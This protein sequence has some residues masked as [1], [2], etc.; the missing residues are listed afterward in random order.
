LARD[1]IPD[2]LDTINY[3]V[4][5]AANEYLG[6][7][8]PEFF[9]KV[10]EYHLEEALRR[11]FIKLDSGDKPL[12]NLIRIAKYLEST[13]YMEKIRIDTISESEAIVDM[14]GV[15]V[16]KSS[17]DLLKA[18]KHPSHYMTNIMIAALRKLGIVAELRDVE[19]DE[20]ERRFK[21]HW[22]IL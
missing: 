21:E 5:Q 1:I 6:G 3:A 2:F 10:G 18:G 12:N 22:K 19:Y 15:S 11:G 8:T 13:G 14:F 7:K 20:K 9:K 17:V 16:T 4:C